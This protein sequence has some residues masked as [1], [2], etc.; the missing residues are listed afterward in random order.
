MKRSVKIKSLF[1]LLLAGMVLLVGIVA[2]GIP[3]NGSVSG[4]SGDVTSAPSAESNVLEATSDPASATAPEES[5]KPSGP[6]ETTSIPDETEPEISTSGPEESTPS[7]P[8]TPP[9]ESKPETSKPEPEESTPPEEPVTPPEKPNGDYTG[10]VYLTFDDGP[11]RLTPQVLDILK[12][13]GAKATFFVVGSKGNYD[14]MRRALEE[15]HQ[16]AMHGNSHEYAD[17]YKSV[18]AATENFFAENRKLKEELGIDVKII[19]FPGGSSNTVSKKYCK[20]VMTDAARILT[21]NGYNYFDWDVSSGD[22][23][24]DS[25]SSNDIYKNV[26]NGVKPSKTNVVL[27]HDGNGHEATVEALPRILETLIAAGYRFEPITDSTPH[28]RHTIAN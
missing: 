1:L 18:E 20:N 19:R 15:G 16:I 9:E 6:S 12:E 11:S 5:S 10:I 2:C 8:S 21:E 24:K 7:E 4:N 25:K 23:G 22:A 28:V 14:L 13:Y 17:I 27:M 3:D 26:I